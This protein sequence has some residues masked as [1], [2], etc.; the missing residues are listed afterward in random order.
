MTASRVDVQEPGPVP[1]RSV[2]S[3]QDNLATDVGSLWSK[4]TQA[5]IWVDLMVKVTGAKL[6]PTAAKYKFCPQ[7]I[8]PFCLEAAHSELCEQRNHVVPASA[9]AQMWAKTPPSSLFKMSTTI[10]TPSQKSKLHFYERTF[11][12]PSAPALKRPEIRSC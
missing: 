2:R 5:G 4:S 11:P 8:F 1:Q 6:C 7:L 9:P 12:T 3:L 10:S